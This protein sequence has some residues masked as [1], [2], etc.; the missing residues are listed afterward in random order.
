MNGGDR[1]PGRI[2]MPD[3]EKIRADANHALREAGLPLCKMVQPVADGDTMNP[4]VVGH[5]D[6]PRYVI[7]VVYPHATT[8]PGR[9]LAAAARF[10][11]GIRKRTQLPVPEHYCVAVEE[12]GRLP[13][14]IMEFMPGEQLRLALQRLPEDACRSLCCDWGRCIARFHDPMLMDL[15]GAP[16]AAPGEPRYDTERAQTY[17]EQRSDSDWHRA[18]RGRIL[19]YL[20]ERLPVM[21][22]HELPALTKHGLDVRDFVVIT[23]PD[24]R[25]SGML[26]WEGVGVDDAL[27]ALVAVWIRLHYLG[28]GQAAP[29]FLEAYERERGIKLGQSKRVEFHLMNRALLPTNHNAPARVIVEHLLDGAEYPFS[30]RV[31]ERRDT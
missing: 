27:K 28:V 24:P 13:L 26:D 21:G 23:E 14:V 9:D 30:Q 11:N 20:D 19:A 4:Q 5:T 18:N 12:E 3:F 15:L 6:G 22:K 8:W 25:I 1:A 2:P 29:S 16:E 31:C 7:K 10:A 17:L